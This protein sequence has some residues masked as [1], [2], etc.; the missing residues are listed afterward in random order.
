M[1]EP[2][3]KA[4]ILG[5]SFAFAMCLTMLITPKIADKYGRKW[6]FKVTR[7]L[8]CILYTMIVTIDSYVVTLIVLIGLGIATP[9]RLTVGVPYMNEWFPRSKQT[10]VQVTR[11]M[12]QAIVFC[13]CIAFYWA[14]GNQA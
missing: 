3:W 4:S 10:M 11:I 1:C 8:D 7:I 9:G 6:V 13:I 2:A 5:S 12:E 14:I